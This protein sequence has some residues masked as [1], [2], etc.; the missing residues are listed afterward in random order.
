MKRAQ[1]PCVIAA[2]IFIG[3]L[4]S[5][6]DEIPVVLGF[7]LLLSAILGLIFPSRPWLT[8]LIVGLPPFF[9]ETLAHFGLVHV[10]Y[11]AP[12]GSPWPA[13]LGLVPALGGAL[14]ASAV[15]HLNRQQNHAS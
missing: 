6:T 11:L 14:L 2:A 9:I 5:H 7:V 8:G 10:R 1:W 3:V 15:R 13:L 12:K 4:H